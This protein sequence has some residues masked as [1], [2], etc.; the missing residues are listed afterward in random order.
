MPRHWRHGCMLSP[1]ERENCDHEK[2][3]AWTI[4]LI[5]DHL[6]KQLINNNMVPYDKKDI[7]YH[8]YLIPF[9]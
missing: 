8:C 1:T 6:E 5:K 7:F 4:Q 9:Q 3:D 2:D